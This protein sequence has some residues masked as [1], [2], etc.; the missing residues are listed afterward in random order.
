MCRG[1]LYPFKVQYPF[2]N[3]DPKFI[4]G[5][6]FEVTSYTHGEDVAVGTE[7]HVPGKVFQ[8]EIFSGSARNSVVGL[9]GGDTDEVVVDPSRSGWP[10]GLFWMIVVCD[11]GPEVMSVAKDGRK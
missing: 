11:E 3:F 7:L 4:M 10:K 2:P 6:S 5:D 9:G 1:L 8:Q